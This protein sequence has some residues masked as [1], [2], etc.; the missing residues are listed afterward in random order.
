M[1]ANELLNLSQL[2]GTGLQDERC[3]IELARSS[4][5]GF[6]WQLT[7]QPQ[8]VGVWCRHA[9]WQQM[10]ETYSGLPEPSSLPDEL[11]AC[12]SAVLFEPAGEWL[13]ELLEPTP[14]AMVLA[15]DIYPLFT[16]EAY[17]CAF[18]QVPVDLY[19]EMISQWSPF[20][21]Q[22]PLVELSLVAGYLEQS[23]GKVKLVQVSEGQWL[24]G[25]VKPEQGQSLL[26]WDR[27]LGAVSLD[28]ID[29]NGIV[30]EEM[31]YKLDFIY[32]P[33]IATLATIRLSLAQI[34]SMMEGDRLSGEINMFSQL[35]L[36]HDK[37]P[38]AIGKLLR[39]KGG[40]LVQ[41]EQYC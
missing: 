10:V 19:Q 22:D 35:Q 23:S 39:G 4:G 36:M 31:G 40:L 24:K 15:D 12:V 30:I 38:V 5:D 33:V 41:I 7:G 37:I 8:G 21:G 3:K 13:G 29:V 27:P 9:D 28:D 34:G 20:R 11:L 18:L 14:T 2:I 1:S 25:D 16:L 26:W 6:F 32:Q 17:E